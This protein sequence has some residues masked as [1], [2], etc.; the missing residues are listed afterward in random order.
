MTMENLES[1][2]FLLKNRYGEN[3]FLKQVGVELYKLVGNLDYMRIIFTDD[4]KEIYAV[5]PPGGPF[6]CIGYE[7]KP[8]FVIDRIY[9]SPEYSSFVFN[10]KEK[11]EQQ[12]KINRRR[13]KR[14]PK[15]N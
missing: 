5:D 2:K 9:S 1:N 12:K 11:N 4:G 7:V 8:R 15:D 13:F 6:L 14:K 3:Y 10:I